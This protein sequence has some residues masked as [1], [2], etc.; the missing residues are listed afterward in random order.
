MRVRY[1]VEEKPKERD[2]ERKERIPRERTMS[3]S[4]AGGGDDNADQGCHKNDLF[5]DLLSSNQER[6][7][8][9]MN[10]YLASMAL[11][12]TIADDANQ[13]GLANTKI[14]PRKKNNFP[15]D[16][17]GSSSS[18]HDNSERTLQAGN[19]SCC[20]WFRMNPTATVGTTRSKTTTAAPS[21]SIDETTEMN[22]NSITTAE[23]GKRVAERDKYQYY[24]D[25]DYLDDD[26]SII[27]MAKRMDDA[28]TIVS[29]NTNLSPIINTKRERRR[30]RV[31]VRP[32]P[33]SSSPL[34]GNIDNK[35]NIN[36][37][38]QQQTQQHCVVLPP[39]PLLSRQ[40]SPSITFNDS[41]SSHLIIA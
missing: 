27:I 4:T 25:D 6:L 5:E 24:N 19:G 23:D 35:N 20:S 31:M 14:E 8:K 32:Y 2:L 36:H 15:T 12:S 40:L 1:V 37:R 30:M 33:S 16:G 13:E 11:M 34:T 26:D 38:L 29:S 21:S 10:D 3:S 41:S 22:D 28:S 17:S 18:S 7:M 39:P 9:E